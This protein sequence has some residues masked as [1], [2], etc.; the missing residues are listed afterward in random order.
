[1]NPSDQINPANDQ[2]ALEV[3]TPG[4][5][6]PLAGEKP[7]MEQSAPIIE[8]TIEPVDLI[9]SLNS[10]SPL[11]PEELRMTFGRPLIQN[12]IDYSAY[13]T[14]YLHAV[15]GTEP[16]FEEKECSRLLPSIGDLATE[17]K[18]IAMQVILELLIAHDAKAHRMENCRSFQHWV[19]GKGLAMT[20]STIDRSL[21]HARFILFFAANGGLDSLPNQAQA[22]AMAALPRSHWLH[23]WRDAQFWKSA[24][25]TAIERALPDYAQKHGIRLPEITCPQPPLLISGAPQPVEAEVKPNEPDADHARHQEREAAKKANRVFLDKL[26]TKL[27]AYLPVS[28]QKALAKKC[29]NATTHYVTTTH[30]YLREVRNPARVDQRMELFEWIKQHNPDLADKIQKAAIASFFDRIEKEMR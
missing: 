22:N 2:P 25:K 23:F 13:I 11:T 1:M 28:F 26:D 6:M 18:R 24:G 21:W 27:K 17:G 10:D 14:K 8:K 16:L 4:H 7:A 20:T 15:H 3:Q 29:R 12:G 9:S 5:Y 30:K 19:N